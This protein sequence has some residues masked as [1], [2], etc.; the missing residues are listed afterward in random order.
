MKSY[1]K[2]NKMKK[3]LLK[4]KSYMEVYLQ[5]TDFIGHK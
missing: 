1:L 2:K 4:H 3:S 5:Q